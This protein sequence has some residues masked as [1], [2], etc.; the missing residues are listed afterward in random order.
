M[1]AIDDKVDVSPEAMS[2]YLLKA[3]S[4]DGIA[5]LHHTITG[6]AIERVRH[7][8]SAAEHRHLVGRWIEFMGDKNAAAPLTLPSAKKPADY[9][10]FF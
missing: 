3:S 1:T 4:G 5:N 6:Y 8:L 10:V 7:L 2:R 9:D